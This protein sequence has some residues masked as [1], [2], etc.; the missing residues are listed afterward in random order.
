MR[1]DVAMGKGAFEVMVVE[2]FLPS[3]YIFLFYLWYGCLRAMHE[4]EI[5]GVGQFILEGESKGIM[6]DAFRTHIDIV[7]VTLT[8]TAALLDK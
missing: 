6:V 1:E 4:T 5:A 8:E 3:N 2:S 7:F